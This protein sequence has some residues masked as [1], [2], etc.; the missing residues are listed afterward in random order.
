MA[1]RFWIGKEAYKFRKEDCV[2]ALDEVLIDKERLA[3]G[4]RALPQHLRQTLAI[5]RRYGGC[6]SGRLLHDELLAHKLINRPKDQ[7][8][9]YQRSLEKGDPV[10]ELGHKLLLMPRS[11]SIAR[12]NYYSYDPGAAKYPEVVLAPGLSEFIETAPQILQ[13]LFHVEWSRVACSVTTG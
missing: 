10:L 5:C 11:G 9:Y 6:V 7:D 3:A 13:L 8:Y 4:V 1:A 12:P 2:K